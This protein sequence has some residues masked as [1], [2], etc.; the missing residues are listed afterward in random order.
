MI[1]VDDLD[2]AATYYRD[3][4][5]L[6]EAWRDERQVGLTLPE[7]DAG[8]VHH[9]DAGVSHQVEVH[10]LVDDVD[11]FVALVEQRGCR[12]SVRPFDVTIGRCAVIEDPF[13]TT[14]CV[15]DLSKW[16]RST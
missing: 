4:F 15:P 3:T 14:L 16:P 11:T 13:G 8:V 5:G 12:I 1:H 6:R 9:P 10:Y 7:T 2:R